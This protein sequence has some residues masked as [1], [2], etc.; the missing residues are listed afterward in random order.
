MAATASPPDRIPDD[1]TIERTVRDFLANDPR[2]PQMVRDAI[3]K[4]TV[5]ACLDRLLASDGNLRA[6][7]MQAAQA[8]RYART[9]VVWQYARLPKCWRHRRPRRRAAR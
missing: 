8:Q 4:A 3:F 2:V 6:L 1:A 9:G 7:L 5:V